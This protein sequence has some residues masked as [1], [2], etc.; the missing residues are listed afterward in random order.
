MENSAFRVISYTVKKHGFWDQKMPKTRSRKF[1]GFFSQKLPLE[2]SFLKNFPTRPY[3]GPPLSPIP[4]RPIPIDKAR[5]E[6]KNDTKIM[7]VPFKENFL[8]IKHNN[9]PLP[10]FFPLSTTMRYLNARFYGRYRIVSSL[11]FEFCDVL[12]F[13]L[14]LDFYCIRICCL[15]QLTL[16][17]AMIAL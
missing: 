1:F 11:Y 8:L 16:F 14:I 15:N 9:R 6:K 3:F 10:H 2:R 4:S 5:W 13:V 7:G 17:L 12:I